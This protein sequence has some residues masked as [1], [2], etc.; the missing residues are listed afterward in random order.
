MFQGRQ[1]GSQGRLWEELIWGETLQDEWG[2]GRQEVGEGFPGSG[3]GLCVCAE[4][5]DMLPESRALTP[6]DGVGEMCVRAQ[7]WTRCPSQ[8]QEGEK[9][10]KS[11][12]WGNLPGFHQTKTGPWWRACP[13]TRTGTAQALVRHPESRGVPVALAADTSRTLEALVQD[14]A[15]F[16][17]AEPSEAGV[18]GS[19]FT[20]AGGSSR[21][22][23]RWSGRCVVLTAGS[24]ARRF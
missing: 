5:G 19:P 7:A 6:L 21:E 12:E 10:E 1:G 15:A 24:C 23:K 18:R 11:D 8:R 14:P 22:Q 17:K 20:G 16:R 4:A 3:T 9:R 2:A 13:G